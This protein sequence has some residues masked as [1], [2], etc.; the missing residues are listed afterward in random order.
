[1]IQRRV[2]LEVWKYLNGG[3]ASI[4][5]SATAIVRSGLAGESDRNHETTK[6]KS[7]DL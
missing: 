5:D 4:T 7:D 6:E 2:I 1:M 3:H